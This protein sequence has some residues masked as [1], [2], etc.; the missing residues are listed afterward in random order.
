MPMPMVSLAFAAENHGARIIAITGAM[1]GV[2]F[3]VV[4]LRIYV[5]PVMLRTMGVMIIRS[6]GTF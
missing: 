5:R 2:S 6:A 4:F 3:L 1:T